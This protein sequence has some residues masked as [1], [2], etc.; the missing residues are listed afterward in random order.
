MF[1][2]FNKDS[3]NMEDLDD[4]SIDLVITSPPYFS[5]KDYDNKK[6]IGINQKYKE[7]K[8]SLE[9]VWSEC[10]RVLKPD[11]KL[12]I[13]IMPLFD[14]GENTEKK[15]KRRITKIQI[16]EITHFMENTGDMFLLSLYIWDKR[17]I[18]RFSSFGSYPYPTNI[19]STYP[20]EWI[21]VYS[22]YGKRKQPSKKIKEKSKI[23]Q[24]E[25]ADF[26][27]N[28]IWEMNP[29]KAKDIGHPAPFP[30]E[31]PRRI[32]KLHSF[33]GD[34]ILDPFCGSG[35]ALKVAE[36]LGRNSVGYDINKKY[37]SLAKKRLSQ[38]ILI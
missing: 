12:C 25:W 6:Q 22:K 26:A 24:K 11:G 33:Y 23:T 8:E 14:K 21:I 10:I 5:L 13:N 38:S 31:L 34:T 28:S 27:I 35:T 4:E 7:Y 15:I 3:R 1:K 18:A 2:L 30:E 19:F 17:K 36:E 9:K 29:A 20:Y 16:D 37:I 32:I